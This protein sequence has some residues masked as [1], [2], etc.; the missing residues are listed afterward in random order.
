MVDSGF[1]WRYGILMMND[2]GQFAEDVMSLVGDKPALLSDLIGALRGSWRCG[3]SGPVSGRRWSNLREDD[4]IATLADF[5]AYFGAIR[6]ASGLATYVASAPFSEV[7]PL[8][9]KPVAVRSHQLGS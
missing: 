2:F 9:R 4:V 6:Y 5:G 3:I 1:V 7:Q 8:R